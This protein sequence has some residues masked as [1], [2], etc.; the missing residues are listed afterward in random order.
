M[1]LHLKR[2]EKAIPTTLRY[3]TRC[4]TTQLNCVKM[5]IGVCCDL[6]VTGSARTHR[7]IC[8]CVCVCLC[9][10]V[11]VCVCYCKVQSR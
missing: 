9:V 11:F 7:G 1:S 4:N 3:T 10:C 6:C 8:E 5:N 2:V